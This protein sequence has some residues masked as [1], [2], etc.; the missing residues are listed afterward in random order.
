NGVPFTIALQPGFAA[1]TRIEF[2]LSVSTAQGNT[3]LLFS[4]VSGTPVATTI[5]S[6]NFGS[7]SAGSLPTGWSTFHAGGTPTVRWTTSTSVPQA[8]GGNALFHINA[9]DG[10]GDSTRWERALSP[11]IG[12]PANA[13]FA[14]LDFDVWYNTED[15]PNFGVLAY[16][17]FLL[18]IV[19]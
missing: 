6:E 18:R 15:D 11:S 5:F 16:D 10:G 7:V 3:T 14:T 1:G 17:G 4:L 19:D 8:P 12:V 9:N 2:A 13:S